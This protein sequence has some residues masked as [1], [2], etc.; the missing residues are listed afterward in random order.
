MKHF[1]LPL[2]REANSN[3]PSSSELSTSASPNPNSQKQKGNRKQKFPPRDKEN[4]DP[5]NNFDIVAGK[6][7]PAGKLKSPLP[8]KPPNPLKRKLISDAVYDV[9]A[10][11]SSCSSSDSGVRVNLAASLSYFF[12]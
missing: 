1:M 6:P 3:N 4:S 11:C 8:P 9:I 7:S 10:G 12:L 5:G 2:L